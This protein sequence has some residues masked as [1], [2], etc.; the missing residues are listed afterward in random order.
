MCGVV[1]EVILHS[2]RITGVARGRLWL[3]LLPL[4][5]APLF[6]S[7]LVR[8]CECARMCEYACVLCEQ[9]VRVSACARPLPCDA[10]VD[11]LRVHSSRKHAC[12]RARKCMFC[13]LC[14]Q[15]KVTLALARPRVFT[16]TPTQTHMH[17]HAHTDTHPHPLLKYSQHFR[18]PYPLVG[19]MRRTL[20]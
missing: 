20:L 12:L 10:S 7:L 4:T 11:R 9:W 3:P 14:G 13:L 18:L 16:P 5:L 6:L 8:L 15:R 17:T 2:P 19:N 1:V